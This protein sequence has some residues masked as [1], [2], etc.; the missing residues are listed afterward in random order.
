VR[1]DPSVWREEVD[2]FAPHSSARAT[3]QRERRR[4]EQHGI[5]ASV[6]LRCEAVGVDGTRLRGLLKAYVPIND[7]PPSMRPFGMIFAPGV[8]GDGHL[9]LE[10]LAFG[11]RHA[12]PGTRTV[13]E[14]AHWR[15]YGRYPDR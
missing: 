5:S 6:L 12:R 9:Y 14:R 10:L 8:E 2:R 15:L 13:Y 7:D 4:L 1:I 3:A 11:E